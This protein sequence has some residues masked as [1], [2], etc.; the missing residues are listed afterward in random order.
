MV[1]ASGDV[2]HADGHSECHNYNRGGALLSITANAYGNNSVTWYG[3]EK[4][5]LSRV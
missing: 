2:G 1:L 4:V 5:A 3:A